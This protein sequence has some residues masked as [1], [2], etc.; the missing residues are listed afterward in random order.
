[1]ENS[2]DLL[3]VAD[4]VSKE[5]GLSIEDVLNA[6]AEGMETALRH[7]FPEGAQL[8]VSIDDETGEFHAYRLFKLVDQIE[9]PEGEMLFSEIDDEIVNDGYVWEEYK[10]TPNRQQF[11]I[12]KQVAM[13]RIKN[14]SREQQILALLDKPVVLLSG[15]V[16]VIKKEQMIVDC[17]GLDII[18]PR[19]NLLPRDNYKPSDKIYFVLE[20]EKNHYVG[21]RISDNYLIEVFKRELIEVEEGDIEIVSVAR[22]PG[23]RS[24][25][26]VKSLRKN[27]DAV[28]TC[29]GSKG[30][31]I[32]N[33]HSFLNGEIVDITP[34]HEEPA[35]LLIQVMAPVN[36]NR[37]MIDEELKSMDV[38]VAD[39]EIAMAIGKGGKNIEMISKLL[40]WQI[41]VFSET[42]WEANNN[43]ENVKD[44]AILTKGLNCEQEVAQLILESG[45]NS[46]QEIAYLP[47]DEFY[48]EQLDDESHDALRE[49]AKEI[50]GNPELLNKAIGFGD[51]V[52]NGLEYNEAELLQ[53][54]D[55]FNNHDLSELSS[56]ELIDILPDLD[57]DRAKAIIMSARHN[58]E[59]KDVN[60]N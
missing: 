35:Q 26:V 33:I 28:R 53:A 24:K 10:F 13:Q 22:I 8:H 12:T 48:V 25:V 51:L 47:K 57:T 30:V 49:N 45:Y 54:Q 15:I 16:K 56:Y 60:V 23:F 39:N 31:H 50:C 37:I 1:M 38:T 52:S 32:K 58:E 59:I 19:R 55:V 44:L 40:G 34:Y 46:L 29:I 42:Q 6:L 9:N 21:T 4:I 2:K 27:I 17:N 18:I 5:K 43:S 20:K 11:A 14:E 3:Q 7:S 41:N 36:V